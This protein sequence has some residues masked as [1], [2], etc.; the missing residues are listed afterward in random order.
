M[1]CHP[2]LA[3]L[4]LIGTIMPALYSPVTGVRSLYVDGVLAATLTGQAP[5]TGSTSSHVVIGARDNGGNSFG[6]YFTGDIFDV[7]I[8]N[9]A[10]SEA[11]INSLLVPKIL[12][13]PVFTP[14]VLTGNKLILQW[15]RGTLLQATN[16]S[17]PWTAIGTGSPY[18][19]D[20]TTSPHM[21]YKLRNP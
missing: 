18:T 3:R 14:P 13:T 1:I 19:N 2:R 6:N 9:T 12:P 15:D 20:V 7:R 8:Y 4:T 10:L 16:L 11:Q 5:M 21:F 17:G